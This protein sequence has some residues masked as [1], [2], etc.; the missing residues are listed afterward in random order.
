[1]FAQA[2]S[3]LENFVEKR[4]ASAAVALIGYRD[5]P[6]TAKAFGQL[7]FSSDAEKTQLDS[8]FDL[9]SLTKVISTTTITLRL[10]E[11]G[12]LRLDTCLGEILPWAPTYNHSITIGQ[13][14]TH[15]AGLGPAYRLEQDPRFKNRETALKAVLGAPLRD[16]SGSTVFYS[17]RGFIALALILE[18]ITSAP[19][20][21]LFSQIVAEP[22]R[23]K[24]TGYNPA[25]SKLARIACTEWDPHKQAF[26]RG[27][28]HDE[29]ARALEGV[30]GNAGLFGTAPELGVFCQMILNGGSYGNRQILQPATIELFRKNYSPDKAQPRTLGWV[31]PSPQDCFGGPLLSVNSIGHTGFTGTS[32]WLDFSRRF[33]GVLL[34]NRVHPT[35]DNAA[36]FDLRPRFYQ[37][38]CEAIDDRES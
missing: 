28:V 14:L 8:I 22:L 5:S 1:M 31:L 6:V 19:L 37:S 17:C 16:P 2:L 35:R 23:F 38:I 30:S 25:R 27:I 11:E 21:Q 32:I 12:L 9:A 33:Y 29:R 36:I 34:T 24:D 26:W 4:H 10:M 18:K 15:S 3:H 13:L 20:D 7:C